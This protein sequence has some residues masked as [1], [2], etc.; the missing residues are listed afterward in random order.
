M[1]SFAFPYP[2]LFPYIENKCLWL[3]SLD[4]EEFEEFKE[5]LKNWDY[6]A[7]LEIKCEIPWDIKKIFEEA[8]L[9]EIFKYSRI[10]IIEISAPGQIS[11]SRKKIIEYPLSEGYKLNNSITFTIKSLNNS[12]NIQFR[13]IIYTEHCEYNSFKY[14][15]GSILYDEFSTLVLEGQRARISLIRED[16]EIFGNNNAMWF[17]DFDAKSLYQ[18]F[19]ET[20]TL[21]LNSNKKNLE[22]QIRNSIYLKDAIKTDLVSTIMSS[23]LLNEEFDIDCDEDYPENSLGFRIKEWLKDFDVET[24]SHLEKFK[25]EIKYNQN[26]FKRNCQNLFCVDFDEI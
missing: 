7:T 16:F 6:N 2:N 3:Y 13:I 18:T 10:A 24:K 15:K 8:D 12:S 1:R 21:Y 14:K 9:N 11:S 25:F 26:I 4:G 17:I 23:T 20:Y 19:N 22:D 5:P